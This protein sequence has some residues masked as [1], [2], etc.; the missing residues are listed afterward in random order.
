MFDDMIEEESVR[1]QNDNPCA[2]NYIDSAWLDKDYVK[3]I[4]E[5]RNEE[6]EDHC[7]YEN[8]ETCETNCKDSSRSIGFVSKL[9]KN[10]IKK[11]LKLIFSA[12]S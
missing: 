6:C 9:K 10:T 2:P 7:E 4:Q 8:D 11:M 5:E 3:S 12:L 1:V